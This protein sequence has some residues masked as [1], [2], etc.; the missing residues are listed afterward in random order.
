MLITDL[1]NLSFSA[2]RARRLRSGLTA[3]GIAVGIAAVVLLTSMGEGLHRFVLAE[4][5]Q[6]GTNLIAITPGK[7]TTHGM[8]GAVMSNV[9]PL[10]LDDVIAVAQ[11]PQVIAAVPMVQGN[12]AVEAEQRQRRTTVLGVGHDMPKVWQFKVSAGQ[13]LPDDDPRTARAFIVLG[14]RVKQ[15]LFGSTVPLGKFVRV[16]GSRFR[17]IGVMESKGQM[18]GFDLD[19]A[20]YIPAAK[21]MELFNR[22]SLMEIDVL[23]KNDAAAEVVSARLKQV[24]MSRHGEEDFTIVTQEQMLEVL[25]SVLDILTFAVG[26]LGGISL[27]V[28]GVGILTIM[29]IAVKERTA[30]IGLLT[31]LGAERRQVLILF[32]AEAMLLSAIG[33]V[34]GLLLGWSISELV[35]F[36]MPAIPVHTPWHFALLAV[37]LAMSVGLLAGVA[38]ARRAARM[39]P[40]DALRTE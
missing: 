38:P 14:S 8:S 18:L 13:F 4:F 7:A 6:F 15:E 25:S 26:A 11:L 21:S 32:L 31:A 33:G 5:S 35:H 16:G 30:E 23:Y 24:L 34:L 39:N 28:G 29:T 40:V 36:I 17:V 10:S 37:L 20:V 27:V 2:V 19:D 9:R 22:E 3:L 12:A 1:V